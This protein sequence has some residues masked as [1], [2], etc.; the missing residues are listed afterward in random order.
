MAKDR[1]TTVR[2]PRELHKKIKDL[3]ESRKDLGYHTVSGFIDRAVM[4]QLD[5]VDT[6]LKPPRGED[7]EE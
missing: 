2:I 7:E 5:K 4:D 3:I 6:G 1:F